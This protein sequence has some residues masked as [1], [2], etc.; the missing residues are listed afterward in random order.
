V[1]L[2]SVPEADREA[3][4]QR[5]IV[6]QAQRPFDLAHDVPWRATLFKLGPEKHAGLLTLHHIVTDA[7]SLDILVREV[8]ALYETFAEGKNSP[9]PELEVQYAD[10][11]VWQQEWLQGELLESQLAYWREQLAGISVLRLPT[12]RP[13]NELGK[14]DFK[15]IKCAL[16]LSKELSDALKQFSQREGLTL[17]MTT[18]TC[19]KVLLRY[20]SGQDD[21]VVGTDV[22]NRNH[23]GIEGLIGFFVN[24]LVLRTRVDQHL[25][26]RELA[27]RVREVALQAYTHQDVPFEKLVETVKPSR[28]EQ[29]ATLF[30]VKFIMKNDRSDVL[31][32]AGLTLSPLPVDNELMDMDLMISLSETQAGL[33]GWINGDPNLFHA[34]TLARMRTLFETLLENIVINPERSVAELIKLLAEVDRHEKMAE[35]A[36]QEENKLKRFRAIKPGAVNLTMSAGE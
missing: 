30:Q 8:A 20:L 24:Q 3:D 12:D 18:L 32:L 27:R 19:F 10:Y 26:F 28:N 36:R 5:S 13:R 22:S 29:L 9:L 11:A 16:E 17:L 34:T 6:E 31:N 15:G 33:R 35:N 4:T 14:R 23:A 7:W 21:I 1:D 2:S 25:S